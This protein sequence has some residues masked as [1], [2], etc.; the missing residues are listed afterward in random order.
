MAENKHDKNSGSK[1]EKRELSPNEIREKG[2]LHAFDPSIQRA[3]A[4]RPDGNMRD[5]ARAERTRGIEPG[6]TADYELGD[7]AGIE[8]GGHRSMRPDAQAGI[9]QGGD[10][11][12]GLWRGEGWESLEYQEAAGQGRAN[13]AR[14]QGPVPV[15]GEG[16]PVQDTNADRGQPGDRRHKNED[17]KFGT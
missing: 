6:Q 11:A 17:R 7:S 8:S 13:Q 1:Q 10:H 14:P 5:I 15:S 4:D 12:G 3:N 9:D 2:G 16:R